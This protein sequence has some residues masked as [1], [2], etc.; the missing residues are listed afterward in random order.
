MT[1]ALDTKTFVVLGEGLAAG[2][3]HFSL[4]EDVQEW[5]F[6]A[7]VAEK[8]G[9]ELDQPVL[10]APGVGNVGFQPQPAVV[11]D[12]LQTSVLKDF[13]RDEADL[14]NL[15]V[16]GFSVADALERRPRAPMVW[17]DD[18]QQTL[19]NLI[20]G[21]PGLTWTRG[22]LPTQVEYA[23]ARKPT[24]VLIALGYQEVLEPL[25]P[26]H[27]HGGRRA[28]LKDFDKN[29]KK[30]LDRLAGGRPPGGKTTVV[31]T[32]I[33]N[34]L[35]TAYFSSLETAAH[36]LRTE[37]PFLKAQFDLETGDL[38]NLEG[39][40]EIGYQFLARQVSGH[41]PAGSVIS[42]A[43]AE[44]IGK[45]VGILNS[46][47]TDLAAKKKGA[48]VFDLHGYLARV[49]EDGVE[50]GGKTLTAD[51]LG[52]FY[53]LNGVFPGRTGHA[54]IANELLAIL[55][56]HAGRS[57]GEVDAAEVMKDDGN[58]L[59]EIARGGTFTDE[60]LKPRTAADMPPLAPGDPSALNFFP[61]FDP[62]KFNVFPIQTAYPDSPFDIGGGKTIHKCVPKVGIPAGGFSD[63]GIKKPLVLPEGLEQTLELSK[64]GSYFGDALR[65]VDAPD[66]TPFLAGVST[67]GADGNTL[68]GGLAM[69][70]SHV[71]GKIKIRFTE[72]DEHGVT[73]FE[74]THPGGL[75]GDDGVLAAPK[76]FKLPAQHNRVIDVPGLVSSGELDL[77][78]GYVTNFRYNV[79]F[80]N[81]QIYTLFNVNPGLPP[82]PLP[83]I[84]PGYPN[85]GSTWARFDQR[86]DGR[87]DVT[88][89]ANVWL[90]LGKE[91]PDG[92]PIRFP[93]P[94]G[95]PDL[96]C[97]SIVARGTS[98]H[99]HIH[100]TT[101]ETPGRDL[102]ADAP[103]IPINTIKEFAV[104]GHNTNFGDVFGLHIDELDGEGTGRS[105]LLGRLKFQFGPRFGDSVPFQVSFLPPGG[106]LSPD[107][108]P[109]PYLPPGTSRGMI[110]CNEEL[111]F[112]SG[113]TYHQTLL[114]S[115]MDPN[116]LPL[117]AIDLK[118]GRVRGEFLNRSF[119]VQKLFVNLTS[120]EPCTPGDSF[121]YQGPARFE[122]GPKGELVFSFNGEVFIPYPK[123]FR[124][125]SPSSDGRP[126]Y[127]VV[128]ESRLDP[129]LRLQAMHGG[130]P[131]EGVLSSGPANERIEGVSSIRQRF[132]YAFRVPCDPAR[133]EDAFFEYENFGEEG[134]G[135]DD[136]K[137]KFKLARLSWV[138]ASNSRDSAAG[139]GNADT[140]TFGGFGTW[141]E[142]DDLH[143]VSVH[144]STAED[145]PYVGIQVDGGTT[146]N[147]NTKPEDIETTIPLEADD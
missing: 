35:D 114:S 82:G 27:I 132:T 145:E 105:H 87:L 75:A 69:T 102:G 41:L 38:I 88:M 142:D 53:L 74:I 124:F 43:D 99:P 60:Y 115:S 104:F 94:F 129:F 25:V 136:G 113:V 1:R 127:L 17:T 52:G 49:A 96:E 67:F 36:I 57:F 147:V 24:L 22:K 71:S 79:L 119:V 48:L 120:V 93:L 59:S 20:L 6:P 90:P 4:T 12:L 63:P 9:T 98:L 11:P 30:L 13:P 78:T 54:L 8:L 131:L 133:A 68:F 92:A 70:D 107:P 37:V 137:G 122:T 97:A 3:G 141:S 73:H 81:T 85:G 51:F 86:D 55:G 62:T 140:I 126:P 50:V 112:P 58:T 7:Q 144:I 65:A 108:V 23:R 100:L 72:P 34:P 46:N 80:I 128:R 116:N 21:V 19:T 56:D 32:T 66:E 95:N 130:V 134:G 101:K 39:L 16:P 139:D 31:A 103:E 61:P 111:V 5:S 118:T 26:G 125:P 123:G 109:L 121:N 106:L 77:N 76:F 83:Q 44:R 10:E 64:E 89:A 33:P 18:P 135:D 29:Y 91:T 2:V 47:I 143:Q 138:R 117:G 45:A 146:S 42:A 15:S 28:D 14:G 40:V 110:G 84:F